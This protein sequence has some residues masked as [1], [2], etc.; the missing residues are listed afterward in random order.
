MDNLKELKQAVGII[1]KECKKH[2]GCVDC[3]LKSQK[4]Y[5]CHI[6]DG[7]PAYWGL[8]E[9]SNKVFKN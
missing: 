6:R 8:S 4:Y 2:R 5:G 9:E 7:A 1:Q 3:P